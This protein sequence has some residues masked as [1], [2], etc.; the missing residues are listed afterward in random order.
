MLKN[1]SKPLDMSD[2][3]CNFVASNRGAGNTIKTAVTHMK[4]YFAIDNTGYVSCA[5]RKTLNEIIEV[6]KNRLSRPAFSD[7]THFVVWEADSKYD[8]CNAR[9]CVRRDGD[10]FVIDVM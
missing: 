10:G 5:C 7:S 8:S 6:C 2:N 4:L 9:R 1:I 3:C